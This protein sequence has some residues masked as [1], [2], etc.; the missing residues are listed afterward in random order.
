MGSHYFMFWIEPLY[1]WQRKS[2]LLGRFDPRQGALRLRPSFF[3]LGPSNRAPTSLVT[4]TS[5]R[6]LC[7]SV[8]ATDGVI[9]P[10]A[11][12]CLG[13]GTKWLESLSRKGGLHVRL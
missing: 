11:A 5:T 3:T 8:Q 13:P 9:R 12:D 2:L 10:R 1:L 4:S 6:S 7:G